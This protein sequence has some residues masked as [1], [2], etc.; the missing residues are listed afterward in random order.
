MSTSSQCPGAGSGAPLAQAAKARAGIG[1]R[2]ELA[3]A[4][5]GGRVLLERIP[6]PSNPRNHFV[7]DPGK[8]DFYAMDCARR[9]LIVLIIDEI[10]ALTGWVNDPTM[11]RRIESALGLLLSQGR[12]PGV[13]ATETRTETPAPT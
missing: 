9:V 3:G 7:V 8:W 5:E 10:A 1:D 13:V 12:A 6:V 4:L 11:K 2:T